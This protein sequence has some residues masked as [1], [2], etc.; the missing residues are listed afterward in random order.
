MDGRAVLQSFFLTGEKPTQGQFADLID[1]CYNLV[2]DVVTISDVSGLAAALA[3]KASAF[4]GTSTQYVKGN[5][6]LA[7][8]GLIDITGA[9]GFTPENTA[10]KSTATALGTSDSLYPSQ[11][12]VKTYVDTAISGVTAGSSAWSA[13]TGTPTTLAGYGITDG[14]TAATA[15]ASYQPIG[16][17]L[18]GITSSLV[19]TALGYT[20]YNGATN[21]DGYLSGITSA[22]VASALGYTP[23]NGATNPNSY[24]TG[25][26]SGQ[27]TAALGYTPYNGATNLSGYLSSVTLTGAVTGAGSGSVATSLANSIVGI[28]NLSATGTASNVT[29]LRGDNTW[30][31]PP[32]GVGSV[33]NSDGSFTISPTT[34]A[35]VASLNVAHSNTFTA[36][37]N[38]QFSGIAS[39]ITAGL[40]LNNP[41]ASTSSATLQ[42]S[43]ALQL[44]GQLWS[45][46][47][48]SNH[49]MDGAIYMTGVP[50]NSSAFD[51]QLTFAISNSTTGTPSYSPVMWVD[52]NGVLITGNYGLFNGISSVGSNGLGAITGANF[53]AFGGAGNV[54]TNAVLPI[55][56]T[57]VKMLTLFNGGS[58]TP[59]VGYT[60]AADVFASQVVSTATS[61]VHPGFYNVMIMPVALNMLGGASVNQTA[62]LAVFGS[63]A[64][65]NQIGIAAQNFVALFSTTNGYTTANAGYGVGILNTINQT[66]TVAAAFTD[67]LF[68]R[69]NTALGTGTQYF[70]DFQVSG[71]SKAH[72]DTLGNSVFNTVQVT[73]VTYANRPAN[74]VKGMLA[75]FTDSTSVT[76][77]TNITTGGG[78]YNVLAHYNGANWTVAAV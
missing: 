22:M 32:G 70:I 66:T 72:V 59:P 2:D 58:G 35:V 29:Y 13:I 6:T 67:L 18:T 53:T 3:G 50:G 15:A 26:T 77:G 65:A 38:I 9:L 52:Q 55:G 78:T 71:T 10:N 42:N 63:N 60:S 16:S 28:S 20:P 40:F 37:Q 54:T 5:G 36:A 33:S 43:P 7:T 61:G 73:P 74:P 27:V 48:A 17:Y 45:T 31:T 19:T 64:G 69:T 8:L 34:G 23:Y 68:N 25:I 21:P 14:L 57:G 12:A 76:W 46:S 1:S 24:L 47:T 44:R 39:A 75:E 51:Q 49:Y 4:T 56:H 41:T 30:G 62:S 11:N